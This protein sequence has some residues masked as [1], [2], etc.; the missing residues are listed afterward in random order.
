MPQNQQKDEDKTANNGTKM[1]R[2]SF[3]VSHAST[4]GLNIHF[5]SVGLLQLSVS[6]AVRENFSSFLF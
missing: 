5:N 4:Q 3:F 1:K 2:N 6:A